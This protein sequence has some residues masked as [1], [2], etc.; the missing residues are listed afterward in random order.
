MALRL[1]RTRPPRPVLSGSVW[2]R[3]D[4]YS[5]TRLHLEMA[6]A[7]IPTA[8]RHRA[9]RA[10]GQRVPGLASRRDGLGALCREHWTVYT[11][12]LRQAPRQRAVPAHEHTMTASLACEGLPIEVHAT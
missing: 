9:P 8:G 10:T 5:G 4:A 2:Q 1:D 11:L 3:S 7:S 6:R 12:A